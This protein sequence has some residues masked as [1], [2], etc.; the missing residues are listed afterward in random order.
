MYKRTFSITEQQPDETQ[1]GWMCVRIYIDDQFFGSMYVFPDLAFELGKSLVANGYKPADVASV[2]FL[3]GMADVE[4]AFAADAA[5]QEE[6]QL[7]AVV[8]RAAN[9][10]RA[11][12][13]GL[14]PEGCNALA[15]KIV[16]DVLQVVK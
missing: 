13:T 16:A 10:I 12:T 9:E 1:M 5:R 6:L 3:D 11:I 8:E 15:R 7:T 14:G 2:E 4:H